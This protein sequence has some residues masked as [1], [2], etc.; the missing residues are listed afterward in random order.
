MPLTITPTTEERLNA[1]ATAR[2]LTPDQAIIA[3]IEVAEDADDLP[4][5]PEELAS[6]RRGLAQADAGDLLTMEECLEQGIA[7]LERLFAERQTK[8]K[9]A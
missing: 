2:G 7:E 6:A 9:A 1:F 3:A 4:L 8:E 5:T